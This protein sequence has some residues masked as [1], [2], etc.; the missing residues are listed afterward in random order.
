MAGAGVSLTPGLF[1]VLR[2]LLFT[3]PLLGSLSTGFEVYILLSLA[4]G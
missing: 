4:A 2:A 1:A 3:K